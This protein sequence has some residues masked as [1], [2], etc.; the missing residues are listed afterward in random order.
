M[1]SCTVFADLQRSFTRRGATRDY[2][3]LIWTGIKKDSLSYEQ[4]N[5]K[6][7]V[8]IITISYWM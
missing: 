3:V 7:E 2:I 1:A 6:I 5:T 4:I 8:Y